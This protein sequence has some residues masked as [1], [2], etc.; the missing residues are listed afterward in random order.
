MGFFSKNVLCPYCKNYKIYNKGDDAN[1]SYAA[2]V[3]CNKCGT[4]ACYGCSKKSSSS[5]RFCPQCDST[6]LDNWYA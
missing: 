4:Q 3:V 5:V 2:G 6:D 1:S